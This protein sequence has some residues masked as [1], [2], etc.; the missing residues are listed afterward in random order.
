MWE[1]YRAFSSLFRTLTNHGLSGMLMVRL[2][3]LQLPTEACSSNP[4]VIFALEIKPKLRRGP[5]VAAKPMRGVGGNSGFFPH[6][7]LDAGARNVECLSQAIRGQPHGF[8]K[9]LAQ[10]LARMHGRHFLGHPTLHLIPSHPASGS[11]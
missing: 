5:E 9:L 10:D 3:L 11:L 8:N 4:Q 7:T 1:A 6:N 2:N